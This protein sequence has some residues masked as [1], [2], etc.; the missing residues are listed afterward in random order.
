MSQKNV[1]P[2][3][4]THFFDP[5]LDEFRGSLDPRGKKIS[6]STFEPLDVAYT[7][8][9]NATYRISKHSSID[10]TTNIKSLEMSTMNP[11]VIH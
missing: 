9:G 7:N 4:C 10:K 8:F 5:Q 1:R 11:F 6:Q 2:T 3:W